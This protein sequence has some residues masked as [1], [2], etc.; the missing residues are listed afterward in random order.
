MKNENKALG[1][2]WACEEPIHEDDAYFSFS[3]DDDSAAGESLICEAC[4]EP[5]Y[6]CDGCGSYGERNETL[7][8]TWPQ[9]DYC[10][11]CLNQ[12]NARQCETCGD[13]W[14]ALVSYS[15]CEECYACECGEH[16]CDD[17]YPYG[18]DCGDCSMSEYMHD[19]GYKPP[20][21][22]FFDAVGNY[23]D[24][25]EPGTVFLGMELE[26]STNSIHQ[27]AELV[28]NA[29]TDD[30]IYCKDDGSVDGFE[31]VTHP[32]TLEAARSLLPWQELRQLRQQGASGEPNGIHVHVSRSAFDSEAHVFKW[33][34]LIYRNEEAVIRIAR[35]K[36]N[37]WAAFRESERIHTK[38]LAKKEGGRGT[39]SGNYYPERYSAINCQNRHTFEVRVFRGSLKRSEIMA[40][41]ELVDA[42]V[43]YTRT[44]TIPKIV[45]GAWEWEHFMNWAAAQ[46][47]GRYDSLVELDGETYED[48]EV[49]ARKERNTRF[50]VRMKQAAAEMKAAAERERERLARIER[51]RQERIDREA[52]EREQYIANGVWEESLRF[53]MLTY[54]AD[55]EYA[56]TS[57]QDRT[58]REARTIVRLRLEATELAEYMEQAN[59]QWTD[60]ALR[61]GHTEHEISVYRLA[62][63]VSIAQRL[64]RVAQEEAQRAKVRAQ[65]ADEWEEATH[66]YETYCN[67]YDFDLDYIERYRFQETYSMAR[68]VRR[69]REQTNSIYEGQNVTAWTPDTL[70]EA[71]ELESF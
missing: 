34:K 36:S 48:K 63:S 14:I 25:A 33:M 61:E 57:L 46:E 11:P 64:Q 15:E 6:V 45:N 2:C 5:Y 58:L 31:M 19:Y 39:R 56:E 71:A 51:E 67:R 40:A 38:H 17:C 53:V 68:D 30:L 1:T 32:M 44:L 52:A 42:S 8:G 65:Y 59:A 60:Q 35:R 20:P 28:T 21:Q 62:Q 10:L 54:G 37:D 55:R 29:V 12:K 24:T 18:C 9:Y 66:R 69:E 26:I 7:H 23:S 47:D 49:T 70:E 22:F 41:L 27:G 43:E 13:V 4:T 16:G 50:H 3:A